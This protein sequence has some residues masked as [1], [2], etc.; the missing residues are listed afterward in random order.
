MFY[1]NV[2]AEAARELMGVFND[3]DRTEQ[4]NNYYYGMMKVCL[5]LFPYFGSLPALNGLV[6]MDG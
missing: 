3:I 6:G 4:L 5:Y 2:C 1:I